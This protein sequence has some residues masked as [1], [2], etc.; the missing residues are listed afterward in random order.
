MK[1]TLSPLLQLTLLTLSMLSLGAVASELRYYPVNPTFGGNP[2]NASGLQANA[3]AQSDYKAPVVAPQTALQKF[4]ANIENAIISKL[5]TAAINGLFDAKGNFN[6]EMGTNIKA[7]NFQIQIT[8][9]PATGGLTL[10]TTDVTSG[11]STSININALG[12]LQ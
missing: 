9:D 7:G 5:Q 10:V 12:G 11:Q 4:T 1:K 6:P 8:T 2:L 3:S